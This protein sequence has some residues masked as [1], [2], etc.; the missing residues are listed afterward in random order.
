MSYQV[1]RLTLYAILTSIEED[2][3]ETVR[4]Q[5]G[6]QG[7]TKE[8]LGDEVWPRAMERLERDKSFIDRDPDLGPVN[9]N[10]V[11]RR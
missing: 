1:T 2:L 8:I 5:I 10:G 6:G 9:T 11:P 7:S 3:R 4:F